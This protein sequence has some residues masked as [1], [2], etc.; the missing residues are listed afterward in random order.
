MGGGG[1]LGGCLTGW[2]VIPAV[3]L[4]YNVYK[5]S[6]LINSFKIDS[7]LSAPEL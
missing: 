6:T 1:G 2:C 5:I 7:L 4:M 3:R